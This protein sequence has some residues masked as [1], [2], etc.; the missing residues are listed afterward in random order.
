[1]PKHL[2]EKTIRLILEAFGE[3]DTMM[4]ISRDL[5][6]SR[7]TVRKILEENNLII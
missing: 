7:H 1:M 3:G 2:T 4:Q 6:V 5:R